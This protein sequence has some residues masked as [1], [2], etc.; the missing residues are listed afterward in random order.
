[1]PAG[2][3]GRS[4]CTSRA[5]SL[6][7]RSRSRFFRRRAARQAKG[8]HAVGLERVAVLLEQ[9]LFGHFGHVGIARS[10]ERRHYAAVETIPVTRRSP[11]PAH[12][13][14]A[15]SRRVWV[16]PGRHTLVESSACDSQLVPDDLLR[17]LEH[18]YGAPDSEQDLCRPVDLRLHCPCGLIGLGII[19]LF[20]V[21]CSI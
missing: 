19:V 7:A 3:H 13:M 18:R 20:F 17:L 14:T 6:R 11:K 9:F 4:R 8:V 5:P 1:M 21:M 10:G 12:R 15:R 16:P 2:S